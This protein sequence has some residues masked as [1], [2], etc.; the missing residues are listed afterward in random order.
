MNAFFDSVLGLLCFKITFLLILSIIKTK[1]LK[2]LI[3]IVDSSIYH[4][5]SI[6][7]CFVYFEV[8]L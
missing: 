7:F 3:I 5:N 6:I 8:M 1:V 4:C 2:S